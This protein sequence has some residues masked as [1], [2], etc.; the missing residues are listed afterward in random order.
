MNNLIYHTHRTENNNRRFTF[1]GKVTDH[2]TLAVSAA[3]CK[4]ANF[5]KKLGRQIAEGRLNSGK[6]DFVMPVKD[7]FNRKDFNNLCKNYLSNTDKQILT[8]I[9]KSWMN[10]P[11]VETVENK[12]LV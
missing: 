1:V 8:E 4:D 10:I 7:D 3:K 5:C 12:L 11:S 2:G 6:I 9:R